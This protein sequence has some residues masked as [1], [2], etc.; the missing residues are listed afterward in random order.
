MYNWFQNNP[1]CSVIS[2]TILVAATTW[3]ISTFILEDRKLSDLKSQLD[4]Q[5]VIT[6][7]YKARADVLLKDVERLYSENTEYKIWLEKD[8]KIV[9]SIVVTEN[10]G[11]KKEIELLKSRL[12][13][14]SRG[15]ETNE[16]LTKGKAYIDNELDM[17]VT[18][19]DISVYND[20]TVYVRLPGSI[21]LTKLASIKSG[22]VFPFENDGQKF[23]INFIDVNFVSGILEFTIEPIKSKS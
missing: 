3:A 15:S 1:A 18:L 7:Q 23:K 14:N 13:N 11:M 6:E 2:H 9:P 5:K 20:A 19:D 12:K 22:E 17:S 21:K 10:L 8:K 16:T 4:T